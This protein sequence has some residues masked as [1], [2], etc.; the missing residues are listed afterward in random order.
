MLNVCYYWTKISRLEQ[1]YFWLH[2]FMYFALGRKVLFM[3]LYSPVLCTNFW[4]LIKQFC[5]F[6]LDLLTFN[7]LI[8]DTSRQEAVTRN[9]LFQPGCRLHMRIMSINTLIHNDTQNTTCSSDTMHCKNIILLPK[10]H[11]IK[12]WWHVMNKL[13]LLI[14][15]SWLR[16]S[17]CC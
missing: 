8:Y 14:I 7:E 6:L 3:H 2:V 11:Y 1:F 4:A 16:S 9:G 17:V 15:N 12:F 13:V 10:L 5:L